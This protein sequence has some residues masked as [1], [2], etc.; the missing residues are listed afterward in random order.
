MAMCCLPG[1]TYGTYQMCPPRTRGTLHPNPCFAFLLWALRDIRR[2][3]Q[4][5]AGHPELQSFV[6]INSRPRA[7]LP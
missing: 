1:M 5:V 4:M 3:G 2:A 7:P 6:L